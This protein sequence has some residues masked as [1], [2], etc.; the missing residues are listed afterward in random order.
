[1]SLNTSISI[2]RCSSS[3]TVTYHLER[4]VF[5]ARFCNKKNRI[6][7]GTSSRTPHPQQRASWRPPHPTPLPNHKDS[8]CLHYQA[9]PTG[10]NSPTVPVAGKNPR[11]ANVDHKLGLCHRSNR[12]LALRTARMD[13]PGVPGGDTRKATAALATAYAAVFDSLAEVCSTPARDL[14]VADP[15][16]TMVTPALDKVQHAVELVERQ[17]WKDFEA[18]TQKSIAVV[19]SNVSSELSPSSSSAAAGSSQVIANEK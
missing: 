19:V 15:F 14:A 11:K 9:L 16:V 1:M 18:R 4:R 13:A 12:G 7:D 3:S 17:R 10:R 6:C 2:L 8:P 5:P